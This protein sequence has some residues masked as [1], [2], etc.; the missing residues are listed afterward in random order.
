M[1]HEFEVRDEIEVAGTP[2]QVWRAIATGPGVDSWF[3]GRTE[4]EPGQGGTFTMAMMGE[5]MS[6]TITAWEPGKHF[7]YTSPVSPDGTFMAFE[8]LL[9]G[10]DGGT[11]VLRFVHSGVLGDNWEDEYDA[12]GKGDRMYMRKLATYVRYFAGRTSSVNLLIDGPQ[13]PGAGRVW[14]AFTNA[15]GASGQVTEGSAV[16][17]AVDGL[18]ATEGTVAAVNPNVYVVVRTDD[19]MHTFLHGFMDTVV[20]EYHG[21]AADGPDKDT[22]EK[23]WRSWLA[24]TFA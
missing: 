8:Y 18:P 24:A 22:A 6:S 11:T 7:A 21:Y 19:G 1:T 10:R 16:R 9:E 4:I 15:L 17:I 14:Q 20:V 5:T 2:E 3:M 13:V 23:A 12:I